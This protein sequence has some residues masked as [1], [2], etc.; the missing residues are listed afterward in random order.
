MVRWTTHTTDETAIMASTA[1]PRSVRDLATRLPNTRAHDSNRGSQDLRSEW[2]PGAR[3]GSASDSVVFL[4]LRHNLRI[5]QLVRALDRHYAL[6]RHLG[7]TETLFELQLR[8][9]WPEEQKRVWL[10]KVTDDIVVVPVKV[11]VVARLVTFSPR[12]PPESLSN[13]GAPP[14]SDVS[15]L[16][17]T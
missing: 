12:R 8:F 17:V 3:V 7:A 4:H 14:T 2:R 16:V 15:V 10:A 5:R 13:A 1:A 6:G 9:T 11:L